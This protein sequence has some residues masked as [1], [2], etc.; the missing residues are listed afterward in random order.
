MFRAGKSVFSIIVR[1]KGF[2][3][4][5]SFDGWSASGTTGGSPYRR[6]ASG[7]RKEMLRE[8][9]FQKAT[10]GRPYSCFAEHYGQEYSE[11]DAGKERAK[12]IAGRFFSGRRG[13]CFTQEGR[14]AGEG[15][16]VS[17]TGMACEAVRLSPLCPSVLIPRIRS[18]AEERIP[19]FRLPLPPES[20][21]CQQPCTPFRSVAY[22]GDDERI[23]LFFGS[24]RGPSAAGGVGRTRGKMVEVFKRDRQP[25]PVRRQGFGRNQ[26]GS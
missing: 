7:R 26:Q 16:K 2:S 22:T 4:F 13:V 20:L 23:V 6:A 19:R 3:V 5:T 8:E 21:V 17:Q 24:D 11:C 12:Q 9:V 18:P 1:V 10:D 15:G 25:G 14:I